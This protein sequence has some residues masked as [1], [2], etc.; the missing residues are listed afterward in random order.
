MRVLNSPATK[1]TLARE[2]RGQP[3]AL[4]TVLDQIFDDIEAEAPEFSRKLKGLRK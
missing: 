3:D 4:R 1:R 2:L